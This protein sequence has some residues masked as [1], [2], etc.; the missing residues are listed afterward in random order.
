M[1]AVG[2]LARDSVNDISKEKSCE[3]ANLLNAQFMMLRRFVELNVP[4]QLSVSFNFLLCASFAAYHP[5]HR[6][7]RRSSACRVRHLQGISA[8]ALD[9][10]ASFSALQNHA[11]SRPFARLPP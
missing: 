6:C 2:S 11:F 8:T 9:P 1:L 7:T 3:D 5:F 4:Y 10:Q